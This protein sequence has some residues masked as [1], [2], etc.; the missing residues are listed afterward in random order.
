MALCGELMLLDV[1]ST[2]FVAVTV[3]SSGILYI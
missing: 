3:T 1:F 2:E